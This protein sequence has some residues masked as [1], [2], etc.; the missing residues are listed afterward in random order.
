MIGHAVDFGPRPVARPHGLR[1]RPRVS[2]HKLACALVGVWLCACAAGRP[3][4]TTHRFQPEDRAA[5]E[6]VIAAQRAAW[7][8]GDLA[9][10]MDGYAHID[11]LVFTSGGKVRRG[12]QDAFDH[13]QARY[14]HDPAGMG[15]LELAI[16]SIDGV[17]A[18]GAVVL[19]TW[20]LTGIAEAGAGV[21]TLV[22]ERRAEGWRI[23]HDHTSSGP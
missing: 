21:F 9:G 4:V 8:H 12:W 6:A 22:F 1:D 5:I 14:G 2:I 15:T 3:V 18:D 17:G 10:Y 7:N 23:V 13:Y 16:Q 11:A 20:R 19:G